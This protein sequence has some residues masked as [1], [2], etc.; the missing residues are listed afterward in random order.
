MFSAPVRAYSL[1]AALCLIVAGAGCAGTKG[2]ATGT[3]GSGGV[4]IGLGGGIGFIDGGLPAFDGPTTINRPDGADQ[5]CGDGVIETEFLETCDDGNKTPDDG[6][7]PLCQKSDLYDCPTPGQPCIKTAKCGNGILTSDEQCDDGNDMANDGCTNCMVDTGWECRVPGRKCVPSCGDGKIVGGEKCDDGNS[8][9]GDGCSSTCLIEPGATCP[10]PGQKC[11]LAVCGNG[12][13]EASEGCDCG[14]DATK[15]PS[16]CPGPNGL[17]FGDG[18]GCSKTCTQEP[19]CRDANGT[20]RACDTTC[21][22]GNKETGEDCD[23]GNKDNGDGC[24]STCKVEGGFSCMDTMK[25]DA[26]DCSDGSGKCLKLPIIYRDFKNEGVSGGHP[27]FFY[28]GA[29]ITGGPSITGV[30]GQTGAITYNQRYCVS[31]SGGPAKKNDSVGRCWDLAQKNLDAK[32]KPQFNTTRNGGGANATL[33]DCQFIDWSHDG[34]GGHV[35]NADPKLSPTYGLPTY[36]DGASGH[37]M[38]RGPA[39]IVKDATSFGQWWVDSSFTNN[40]HIV[41]TLELAQ[42]GTQYQ[43]TS[44][45]HAV[46][47]GFF[48]VDP[49]GQFPIGGSMNGPGAITTIA[50]TGEALLCNLWPYWIQNAFPKCKGDQYLF[51]PSISTPLAGMWVT[52]IQ[53]WYHN[54]WYSTEARYLFTFTGDPFS[55]QFYGDDDLFIFINGI[56]AVDLG[57]VHQRLPGKVSVGA[58]GKATIIE[59]GSVTDASPPVI[60]PCPTADPVT[61]LVPN[62]LTNTDGNGHSNCKD[63]TCDCRNRAGIDLGLKSGSTYEIAVFHADRHPTESNYQLTLSGFKTNQSNCMAYCGDGVATG[64]EEC[65]CGDG[66]KDPPAECA[67]H[68]NDGSYG[69]CTSTCKY[70]PYCGD[71]NLDADAGEECDLGTKNNV[72]G[73]G[74]KGCTPGCK[75]T[76]YCGDA[77][78]DPGEQCDLGDANNDDANK[79]P[80]DTSCHLHLG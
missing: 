16:G 66:S 21:G 28:L 44:A 39:P 4:H 1:C 61:M 59:G 46:Y 52:G 49:P 69:G 73:Y 25:D 31:N 55:L 7:D 78:T 53:G 10:T 3:G 35:P 18:T 26:E 9:D 2:R 24:S 75:R 74:D 64:A 57:G 43:F 50:S 67:G 70:G 51:P 80:C 62:T 71:G 36:V 47:G 54:S 45:P 23:D 5:A 68:S 8:D 34:N 20:T 40:T 65:D 29:K 63:A 32:G 48:P 37:P 15:L 38:Y 77:H 6:C 17:F 72:G 30:Q 56:L 42:M 11:N 13:K 76:H 79:S 60:N 22:N 27:D 14:T 41:G 19:K 33:C 58:D 12:V